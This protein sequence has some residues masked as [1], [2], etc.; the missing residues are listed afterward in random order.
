[1]LPVL[2]ILSTMTQE[3]G[4]CEEWTREPKC[5]ST[6]WCMG[7]RSSSR[8]GDNI[9]DVR[10]HVTHCFEMEEQSRAL[11]WAVPSSSCAPV[12]V[13]PPLH[14]SAIPYATQSA[15]TSWKAHAALCSPWK[16]WCHKGSLPQPR[17]GDAP[18]GCT[19]TSSGEYT[20]NMDKHSFSLRYV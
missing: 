15:G 10:L 14:K 12:N 1:M 9:P 13:V 3:P 19:C 7:A 11:S 16:P 5:C 4:I 8:I 2:G 6:Q 20:L 18:R 17:P